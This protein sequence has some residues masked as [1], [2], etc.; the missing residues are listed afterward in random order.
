[1][2]YFDLGAKENPRLLIIFHHLIIDGVSWRL[3]IQDFVTSYRQLS[4]GEEISLPAKT[5]SFQ[6]WAKRLRDYSQSALLR[7]QLS[8][9][10]EISKHRLSSLP[11][12]FPDGKNTFGSA[13]EVT[14]SLPTKDTRALLQKVLKAKDTRINDVLL[15]A[16]GRILSQWTGE[17]SFL[18]E[19]EG[20]GRE[21]IF[22]DIDLSRTI[23][24]FT[25]IFPV[26]LKVDQGDDLE[27]QLA[28]VTEQLQRIPQNG[29]GYGLLRYFSQDA[30]VKAQVEKLP[31]PEVNFNYLGQFDQLP[32]GEQVPFRVATESVGLEQSPS[33]TRSAL[34]YVVGI[35]SGGQLHI[36]WLYSNNVH[37]R[38]TIEKLAKNY[39]KELRRL[40]SEFL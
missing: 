20:H 25:T 32:E 11:R 18:I 2:A 38:S 4:R 36:R 17:Q 9:W 13:E 31:E 15:T 22:D 23:G 33:A 16:L 1:M 19:M 39:M 10:F 35:V 6:S 21:D 5:T 3:F 12:D 30:S 8:Y 37:R 27:N 28:S 26:L 29:F 24:W 40:I 14:L 34:L 7:E